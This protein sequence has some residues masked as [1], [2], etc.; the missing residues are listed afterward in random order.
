MEHFGALLT[1]S[2]RCKP[3]K[4]G[5]GQLAHFCLKCVFVNL[6]GGYWPLCP[7]ATPRLCLLLRHRSEPMRQCESDRR[8]NAVFRLTARFLTDV[9]RALVVSRRLVPRRKFLGRSYGSGKVDAIRGWS[10][11]CVAQAPAAIIHGGGPVPETPDF[12]G[13]DD[14]TG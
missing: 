3:L 10:D 14:E 1:L 13:G 6:E 12:E 9:G 4:Y 5:S 11:I 8:S 2:V 7:L